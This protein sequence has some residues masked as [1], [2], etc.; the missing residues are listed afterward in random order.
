MDED[1]LNKFVV[2]LSAIL[3]C[4]DNPPDFKPAD[5]TED[6][7]AF[8][9]FA[10]GGAENV[11]AV[12]NG[13]KVTIPA[14]WR[15]KNKNAAVGRFIMEFRKANLAPWQIW[16]DAADKEMADLLARAGWAINRQNFGAPAIRD[17]VY[18][19]W[20]SE[21]WHEGAAQI[22][23]CE[24]ILPNDELLKA[25][26]S[27][28]H[29]GINN[30]GKLCLEDKHSLAARGIESPDR[31][32]AVLGAMAKRRLKSVIPKS[33]GPAEGQGWVEWM[34]NETAPEGSDLSSVAGC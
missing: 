19:S 4:L 22:G 26:L 29:K 17:D 34:Q 32:D 1:D 7:V 21:A 18:I 31:A 3:N 20:G 6:I 30:R 8:C 28:R 33:M 14:A 23:R 16:C 15:E 24:I 10:D 11:L 5:T 2:P 25:Q 27:S 9:D 13:N 12:R